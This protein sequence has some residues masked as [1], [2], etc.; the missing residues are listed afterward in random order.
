MNKTYEIRNLPGEPDDTPKLE[1]HNAEEEPFEIFGLLKEKENGL[2]MRLPTDVAKNTSDR[3][4]A[5]R[6]GT[7]GARIRF[8]TDSDTVGIQAYLEGFSEKSQ[9]IYYINNYIF[10]LYEK[11]PYIGYEL[12]ASMAPSFDPK[13]RAFLRKVLGNPADSMHELTLNLPKETK[14][15]KIEIGIKPGSKLEKHSDYRVK[16]PVVYYGSSITHGFCASR[17]GMS[18]EN[19]ISRNLDCN[20]INLGFSGS[21]YGEQAIA[22]YISG[23]KM[24]AFVLD[25]DHNAPSAEH[26][27]KTHFNVYETVRKKN[28]DIP[29]IMVSKPDFNGLSHAEHLRRCTVMETYIKARRAG[30]N[31]AFFVDGA[32]FLIDQYRGD[33]TADTCHP[34]DLGFS[35]MASAIGNTLKQAFEITRPQ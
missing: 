16:M 33:G 3:V 11:K 18:Y 13:D 22:D 9:G 24:S 25:Y 10:D 27:Q 19:I 21:C 1:W 2:F 32:A 17:P 23:L 6:D 5:M 34:S 7:A 12:C 26:L 20:F 31:L 14:I 28:P 8:A 35:R 4:F 29:I 30:D 15:K